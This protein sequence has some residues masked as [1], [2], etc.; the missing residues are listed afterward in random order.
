MVGQLV[1]APPIEEGLH[2]RTNQA[3]DL[4]AKPE[5]L[6]VAFY[7]VA[8]EILNLLDRLNPFYEKWLESVFLVSGLDRVFVGFKKPGDITLMY[9]NELAFMLQKIL[10]LFLVGL[11]FAF[12]CHSRSAQLRGSPEPRRPNFIGSS[13]KRLEFPFFRLLYSSI[14]GLATLR[15]RRNK[16]V[17]T[18]RF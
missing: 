17:Y 12:E 5:V 3:A 8:S 14:G 7:E 6:N 11:N 10:Q 15:I 16:A 1:L 4:G 18:P 9:E 13:L 2:R